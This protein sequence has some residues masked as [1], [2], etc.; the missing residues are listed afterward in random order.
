MIQIKA[1]H[2][3][4]FRGIRKLNITL[5][6][7]NLGICGPNGTGKS[8]VVDAVEFCITGDVTR[9]S[10][11]GTTGLSVKSHAPHVDERDHPENANVTITAD[12]P[13]L[14]KSVKIY[15]SVKFPK[16][17]KITPND[18]DI[19][20]VIDEL[21]THPEFA[22]SR[23]Q[24]VK[25]IITPPG[26]R[27]EDVQT[28]L[29]LEHLENLRKLFTTFSN[30]RKAEAKEAERG[31]SRA[32]NELKNV[33]N[34]DNFDLAQILKEANKNRQL[35]GLNDL[36]ELIE[37][38]SFKDGISIPE[39]AEKKPTLHK[40]TVLKNL[41]TLISEIK[42]GEPS[43]LSEGR[44]SVKTILEKLIDDDKTLILAQR[45]GFIK[46]GLELVTEDACPLCDKEWNAANL[47]EYLTSKMLSAEKIKELLDKLEDGINS[48]VLS[49]SDRIETIEQT[50]VF[51]NLLTPPIEKS[52]LSEYLTHLNNS[53]KILT[54][55][56][57]EQREPEAAL[58]IVSESW[59]SPK[60]KPLDRINE[61]HTAVIALPDKSAED[62]AR[63][64]L[65]VA[66]ERY[67]KYRASVSEEEKLKTHESL[68]KK[69][70]DQYNKISTGVLED[71]YD[72]VAADFTNY[73]RIINHED[74]DK[75][76][77]KLIS[78]PA[79]LNFDV[80]F[81]G[82]GL[83]PPGAYHSEGHQDGMGICLY[84]ALMKHT[85]GD[86]FTFALLDDVLMSV[87]TGHRREVCRLLKSKFPDA[88]FILTTHDKVWLQ[89]MK[90]EGL[91][92]RSLSFANW[93]I[94]A[95]PRVWDHHDIWGEIQDALNLEN[96]PAAA[97]L[98]RNYL[99]YTATILADNLR[100]RLRFSGD[101]RYDLGDLMPP[102]L[103]EWKKNLEK[104]EKSAAHWK[105]KSEKVLLIAKRAKAKELIA[106][107]NAEEWSINPSVHF[108]DWANFQGSEFQEVVVAF[109]ELL[110]HMRC[111][112]V[113][114][115]SY[116]YIQ[117]RKGT[118]QEMRCNCGATIINLRT[119]A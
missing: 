26:Q 49:L 60:T 89:Y 27:S 109:K 58:K 87:D 14:G 25:Y 101:G 10:G 23:R 34:I 6:S 19:K 96:V 88:Q 46:R 17:V 7:E 76:L 86:N 8:G 91:I 97:S 16:E 4:E 1:I 113:N 18:T 20:S 24:I 77:G 35:I 104:A 13:S 59:W 93:T 92:T 75:F 73:Y 111:E 53:K 107:T 52:E 55:F 99:E 65:I 11:M 72:K 2:I 57:K 12:I 28:L 117:P 36:T 70:L 114:C 54:D 41:T 50:L 31:L 67:E 33:F 37:D 43:L 102:T 39:D 30:K 115:K 56:L 22:L 116:L 63:D 80:D 119:S 40:S 66:Q 47:R 74:E 98:L 82:R 112:N 5:N 94:D 68:A 118:A 100:A 9:L 38:T 106:K 108:N 78:A 45:H 3:E 15:R 81:Y 64:C 79:K 110:E 85:L 61:C 105:R 51:C 44:L 90:T 83:F 48:I 62:E 95:G 84:L 42:K 103:K 21:Q 71:I 69:V 29:R 32:E